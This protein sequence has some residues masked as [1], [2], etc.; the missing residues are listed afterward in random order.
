MKIGP[1]LVFPAS[2]QA[3]LESIES[4][5][6]CLSSLSH[7]NFKKAFT[8]LGDTNVRQRKILNV[9]ISPQRLNRFAKKWHDDAQ[10]NKHNTVGNF[11]KRDIASHVFIVNIL[12]DTNIRLQI[13]TSIQII[14]S[15]ISLVPA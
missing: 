5:L 3:L 9:D 15:T 4:C 2:F 12:N 8:T 13:T 10:N 11:I 14:S 6:S 1:D 7:Q